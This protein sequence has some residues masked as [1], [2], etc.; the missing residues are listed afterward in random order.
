MSGGMG[1]ERK[2]TQAKTGKE[3][4]RLRQSPPADLLRPFPSP[5]NPLTAL[6]Q[7]SQCR[8]SAECS[9][10]ATAKAKPSNRSTP[11]LERSAVDCLLHL[12]FFSSN[13]ATSIH[14]PNHPQYL[15]FVLQSTRLCAATKNRPNFQRLLL[16]LPFPPSGPQPFHHHLGSRRPAPLSPFAF[17]LR[18]LLNF[19]S[20]I[21]I[22]LQLTIPLTLF[23]STTT[24]S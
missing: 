3:Q 21:T 24:N 18:F 10:V 17:V 12:S 22:L 20:A 1:K 9:L 13:F 6:A 15:L 14:S 11:P 2:G 5:L 16:H 19:S 4:V 8:A 23:P 7:K